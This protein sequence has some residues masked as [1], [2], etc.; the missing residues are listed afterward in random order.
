MGPYEFSSLTITTPEQEPG[1]WYEFG[2]IDDE[3]TELREFSTDKRY[4]QALGYKSIVLARLSINPEGSYYGWIEQGEDRP[5]MVQF[6]WSL[7][8]MQ[9]PD[10][11]EASV[12]AGR[13]HTVR[14]DA[15]Q[16]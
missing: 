6:H 4:L 13:G 8:A 2:G 1:A 10:G 16:I 15:R 12:R 14:L 3:V 11:P 5:D 7:Y 9:F